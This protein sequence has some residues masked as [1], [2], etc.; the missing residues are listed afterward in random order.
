MRELLL[1]FTGTI[2]KGVFPAILGWSEVLNP[3]LLFYNP[4]ALLAVG[5][6]S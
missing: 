3:Y 5:V 4:D 6:Q 2:C 1:E